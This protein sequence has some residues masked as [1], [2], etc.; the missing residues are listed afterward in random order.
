MYGIRFGCESRGG[1]NF[2]GPL[3]RSIAAAPL[4]LSPLPCEGGVLALLKGHQRGEDLR[5]AVSALRE[6]AVLADPPIPLGGGIAVLTR[7]D[8]DRILI[9][10]LG[11]VRDRSRVGER[12]HDPPDGG[13]HLRV[14]LI[15]LKRTTERGEDI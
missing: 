14:A 13:F 7:R 9:G 15:A 6:G 12:D 2:S 10:F 1:R 3:P 5:G 8:G 4:G 11:A